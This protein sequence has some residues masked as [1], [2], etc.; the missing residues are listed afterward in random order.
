VRKLI[1]GLFSFI[2]LSGSAFSASVT[3]ITGDLPKDPASTN[4]FNITINIEGVTNEGYSAGSTETYADT[5]QLYVGG[6]DSDSD[7]LSTTDSE[8]ESVKF[9]IEQTSEPDIEQQ[10]DETWDITYYITVRSKATSSDALD[11]A[12]GSESTLAIGLRFYMGEKEDGDYYQETERFN[13]DL[14]Q[15]E[16][17]AN[18]KPTFDK[19]V[20]GTHKE[21][22]I[23]Y[24]SPTTIAAT[25]SKSTFSPTTLSIVAI[26]DTFTGD[27]P[28]KTYDS[29]E[30][31]DADTTCTYTPVTSDAACISCGA[32]GYVDI[33]AIASEGAYGDIAT[34]SASVAAGS[35]SITGLT[36]GTTYTIFMQ[37]DPTGVQQSICSNAMPSKNKTFSEVNGESDA[38]AEPVRCFIATA[39]FGSGYHPSVSLFRKFRDDVLAKT[40]WGNAFVQMYYKLSPPLADFIAEHESLRLAAQIVLAAPAEILNWAYGD[41]KEFVKS[42]P[43]LMFK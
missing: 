2:L 6:G 36:N 43:L 31:T 37:Y 13:Q 42:E 17:A 41:D 29:D 35:K 30:E 33:A 38:K 20:V 40:P 28:G 14:S 10:T 22:V 8:S 4:Y 5:L 16:Y 23:F 19:G 12:M 32:N 9:W 27:L 11:D 1:I 18:A 15:A 7:V 25:G 39:A 34:T 24:D 26:P 3:S 21:L